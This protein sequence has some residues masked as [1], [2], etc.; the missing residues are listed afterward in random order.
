MAGSSEPQG[1]PGSYP[2][3]GVLHIGAGLVSDL[4]AR[5]REGLPHE[6]CGLFAGSGD[7]I[8][9]LYPLTNIAASAERYELDP[10]EQLEAFHAMADDGAEIAGVYHSHPVTPARPSLTDIAEAND[11]DLV[12]LIVSF[13]TE[14]PS[15]RAFSIRDGE[16]AEYELRD[17]EAAST[18][19]P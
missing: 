3:A 7:R 4:V 11:P 9:H 5:C 2:Q 6:A 16:V 1:L 15:I 17:T 8:T 13:A 18:D 14:E 12:Y 10:L 19:A